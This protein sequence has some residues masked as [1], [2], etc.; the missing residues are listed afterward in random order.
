MNRTSAVGNIVLVPVPEQ[1]LNSV[2]RLLGRLADEGN[3]ES[4][5]LPSHQVSQPRRITWTEDD[6]L[7]LSSLLKDGAGRT[8]MNLITSNVG[9]WIPFS[10][11]IQ[12]SG[13]TPDQA[14]AQLGVFT[15]L[16]KKHFY[17]SG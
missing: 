2:Y 11:V 16:V 12:E 10:R 14:R 9:E 13:L 3:E 15:K 4:S 7:R 5:T 1:Y 6:I 17:K 8:V